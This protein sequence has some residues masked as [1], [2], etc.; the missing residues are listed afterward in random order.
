MSF[1]NRFVL[2]SIASAYVQGDCIVIATDLYSPPKIKALAEK[3]GV[4]RKG[5]RQH[6]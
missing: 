4:K 5:N 3:H 1:T 6:K 2:A